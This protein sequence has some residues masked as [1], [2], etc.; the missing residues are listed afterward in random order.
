MKSYYLI[1]RSWP[2]VFVFCLLAVC[3]S[4]VLQIP[5]SNI[6][7]LI[8]IYWAIYG[9]INPVGLPRAKCICEQVMDPVT[10][11]SVFCPDTNHYSFAGAMPASRFAV[12]D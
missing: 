6:H 7:T 2:F 11:N 10:S 4:V 1:L 12:S 3:E 8:S 9:Q 5:S